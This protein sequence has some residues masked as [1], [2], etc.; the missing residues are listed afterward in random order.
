MKKTCNGCKALKE[1]QYYFSCKLNY[2]MDNKN[3]IPLE[4]CPKPKT[5]LKFIELY[6]K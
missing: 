6:K 5:I 3:G 4:C 2:R 1:E